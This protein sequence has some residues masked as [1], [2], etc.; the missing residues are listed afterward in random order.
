[1]FNYTF[2]LTSRTFHFFGKVRPKIISKHL[3]PCCFIA[4]I[5]IIFQCGV[6]S[7]FAIEG[8]K[9]SEFSSNVFYFDDRTAEPWINIFRPMLSGW[10]Q[11]F[12]FCQNFSPKNNRRLSDSVFPVIAVSDI[13]NK[14]SK[15]YS[16]HNGID[17]VK[18]NFYHFL[19]LPWWVWFI[20][21]LFWIFNK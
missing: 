7:S 12:Q 14:R 13:A 18:N 8:D 2:K 19:G 21:I 3:I 5:T 20:L 10:I 4:I 9:I 16:S 15:Q 6:K 1:M 11:S 17:V